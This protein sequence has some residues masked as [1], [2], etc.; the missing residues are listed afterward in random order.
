MN[1]IFRCTVHVRSF[2]FETL[3]IIFS[4]KESKS[5]FHIPSKC[6]ALDCVSTLTKTE[7]SVDGVSV[8]VNLT[9]Y[10]HGQDRFPAILFASL[11]SEVHWLVTHLHVSHI[12][13]VSISFPAITIIPHSSRKD[14][15]RNLEEHTAYFYCLFQTPLV[16]LFLGAAIFRCTISTT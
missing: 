7:R 10:G 15:N 6:F 1:D 13:V 3:P 16:A 2:Q 4:L 9:T 8:L 12:F 5:T 11:L 14:S